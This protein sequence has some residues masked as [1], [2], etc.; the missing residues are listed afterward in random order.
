VDLLVRL[1]EITTRLRFDFDMDASPLLANSCSGFWAPMQL[2][3]AVLVREQIRSAQVVS[4]RSS[5]ALECPRPRYVCSILIVEEILGIAQ[6]CWTFA[7][8]TKN[9]L[10]V[11]QREQSCS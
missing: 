11:K 3:S 7:G 9:E 4:C 8:K 10:V 2:R 1:P 6:H 5:S